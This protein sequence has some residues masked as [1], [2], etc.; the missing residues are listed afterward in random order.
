MAGSA[1][2]CRTTH[3]QQQVNLPLF[4]RLGIRLADAVVLMRRRIALNEEAHDPSPTHVFE[5]PV[6][7]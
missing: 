1:F 2:L 7:V 5:P 3:H 4:A 6:N